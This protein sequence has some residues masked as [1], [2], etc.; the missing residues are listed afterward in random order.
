MI[1]IAS[2]AIKTPEDFQDVRVAIVSMEFVAGSV[3]TEHQLT[4][5]TSYFS[6]RIH[7]GLK[8]RVL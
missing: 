7:R 3:E 1:L 4:R 2:C 6:V 8:H 5:L